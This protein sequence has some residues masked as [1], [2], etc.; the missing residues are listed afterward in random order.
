LSLTVAHPDYTPYSTY[1]LHHALYT[2]G[3]AP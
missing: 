3:G 2:I 1:T